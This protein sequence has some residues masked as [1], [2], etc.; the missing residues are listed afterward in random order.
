MKAE[1]EYE[2]KME[3]IVQS[4]IMRKVINKKIATIEAILKDSMW[5]NYLIF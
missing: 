1:I 2:Q 4:K 5:Q 3:T